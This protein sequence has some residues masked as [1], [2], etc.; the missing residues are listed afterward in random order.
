M[1]EL[2]GMSANVPTDIRFSFAGLKQ[3]GGKTGPHKDGW[4]ITFYEDKGCRTFK[5]PKPSFDSKIADLIESYP[6][7]SH[8]VV[9][10]VRQANRGHVCL[11]NTHPFTLPLWGRNWTFA[12]NGQLTGYEQLD[13]G[14]WQP[15]GETDSERAF[16][17]LINQMQHQFPQGTSDNIELFNFIHDACNKLTALG[18]F[19][20]L[21]S[22]G[23]MLIAYSS[24]KLHWI[25]RKAPFS[26]AQLLDE[27]VAVNFSEETTPSDI[28]TIIATEPLT[29]EPNWI[30]FNPNE[31]LVF[32]DGQIIAQ[33]N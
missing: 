13:C 3:R 27:D 11:Q 7:K 4:G 23:N 22:D 31:M 26:T 25:T 30:K 5:D 9:A 12:H 16:C 28:V 24:K 20:M 18:V 33:Y 8:F 2:L 17:W 19:N 1:C 14:L 10:H 32:T 15:I 29:S 6:I 21:L